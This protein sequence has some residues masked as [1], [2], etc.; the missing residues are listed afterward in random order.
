MTWLMH[1]IRRRTFARPSSTSPR[2]AA[3]RARCLP[4]PRIKR[5]P[6]SEEAAK[7]LRASAVALQEAWSKIETS[8]TGPD[9]R[10]ADRAVDNGWSALYGRPESYAALPVERH[11]KALRAAALQNALFPDGLAFLR[12]PYAAEW[13]ETKKRIDQIAREGW[14]AEID[15]LAGPEFLEEIGDLHDSYGKAIGVTAA[16]PEAAQ[17]AKVAE[18]LRGLARAISA[19]AT[20]LVAA[21]DVE[22]D[23]S[24]HVARAALRPLDD[25]RA[26]APRRAKGEA[27]AVTPTSPLPTASD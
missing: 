9:A 1:S 3:W 27:P 16:R 5:R 10:L 19:Y 4:R 8:T 22:D 7:R 17:S 23:A 11:P 14:A 15:A 20:Q 26:G 24:L 2:A 12:L 6:R 18:P 13:A 21:A 25:H